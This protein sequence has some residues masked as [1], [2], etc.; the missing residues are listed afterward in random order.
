MGDGGLVRISTLL[1]V[2]LFLLWQSPVF[3][4]WIWD[5]VM[6]PFEM[7]ALSLFLL[8]KWKRGELQR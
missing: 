6:I 4:R 2:F 8:R 3:G 7:L 1:V 5:F